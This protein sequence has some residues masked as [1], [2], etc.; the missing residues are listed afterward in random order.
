MCTALYRLLHIVYVKYVLTSILLLASIYSKQFVLI[1][2]SHKSCGPQQSSEFSA[3]ENNHRQQSAANKMLTFTW[4]NVNMLLKLLPQHTIVFNK[5]LYDFFQVVA[6]RI[7]IHRDGGMTCV[8]LIFRTWL[9]C[10]SSKKQ[11]NV[12]IIIRVASCMLNN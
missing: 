4:Y 7:L 3:V 9:N 6:V 2:L 11:K 12:Q 8:I 5:S 10:Q 1:D